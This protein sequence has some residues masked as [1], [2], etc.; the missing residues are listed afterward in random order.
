MLVYSYAPVGYEG[1]VV[2]IEVDIR[3]GLPGTTIVGLPGSVVREARER[4]RIAVANSGHSYPQDRILISLA[5]AGIPKGSAGFDLAIAVAILTA[6]KQIDS[7]VG[8]ILA[9]GELRLDGS[10]RPTAGVIAAVAEGLRQGIQLFLVATA[11]RAEALALRDGTVIGVDTLQQV[12]DALR[13]KA[14]AYCPDTSARARTVVPPG[15]D[16]VYDLKQLRGQVL[17][18]RGLEVAAVGGHNLLL[19]GP[20]GS[21]KTLAARCFPL[22]LPDLEPA[23]AIEVTRIYSQ[24][25]L[26][27]D[28]TGIVTRPP[29]RAPHHSASL[30][31]MVGGGVHVRPG[32]AALAHNGVLFLDE[33]LQFQTN[34]LQALREPIEQGRIRIV[35][36][37]H[38]YWY[39]SSFQLIMTANPCPCGNLGHPRRSCVCSADEVARYWRRLGG[40]LLDRIDMRIWVESDS[41]ELI[42]GRGYTTSFE[43]RR[44]VIAARQR[45]PRGSSGPDLRPELQQLLR[46]AALRLGLSARALLSVRRV[47]R[48]I[49]DLA[50]VDRIERPHLLEAIQHRR[51]GEGGY[52]GVSIP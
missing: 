14:A 17:L 41:D 26:L 30:A 21:G 44:R 19:I 47:A 7:D 5:P 37:E 31:G 51:L 2:S 46:Q 9:M 18:K 34:V 8:A 42:D 24:A 20:P 22:L 49:A 11:N 6:S 33:V 40:P 1:H 28:Q 16:E 36:A 27:G 52:P 43:V 29:V 12:V 39:P 38:G 35:R 23:K 4:V 32:E 25:G 3:R 13:G 15:S 50:A 10:V 45:R 48:T